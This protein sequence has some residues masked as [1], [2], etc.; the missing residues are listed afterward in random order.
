M[1]ALGF[2]ICAIVQLVLDNSIQLVL[3]QAGALFIIQ[4]IH[5]LGS[6]ALPHL[7]PYFHANPHNLSTIVLG[8]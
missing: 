2:S 4:P 8:V 1:S 3:N 5:V 7:I 6:K